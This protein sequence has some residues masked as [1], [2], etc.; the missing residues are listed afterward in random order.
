MKAIYYDYQSVSG[1][2]HDGVVAVFTT[3]EK[4]EAF[5]AL[6]EKF[7]EE[8]QAKPSR[9][10]LGMKNPPM[11]YHIGDYEGPMIDPTELSQVLAD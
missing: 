10:P 1:D 2:I 6:V 4:A 3:Q 8:Y 5:L 7:E 9:C 11:S